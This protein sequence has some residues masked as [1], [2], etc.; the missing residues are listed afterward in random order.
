MPPLQYT[1]DGFESQFGTNH[2]GHQ[3]LTLLL[4]DK[5]KASAP[6]RVVMLSSSAHKRAPRQ[7]LSRREEEPRPDR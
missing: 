7:G 2:I 5:L 3:L 1:A 4:L 6:A